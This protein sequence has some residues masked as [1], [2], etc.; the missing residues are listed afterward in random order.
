M[1][2]DDP[3]ELANSIADRI[4]DRIGR[5]WDENARQRLSTWLDKPEHQPMAI[6]WLNYMDS[7]E[8][9]DFDPVKELSLR[10]P[11][12]EAL[13]GKPAGVG[14]AGFTLRRKRWL[15]WRRRPPR[16]PNMLR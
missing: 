2:P 13:T 7:T 12:H 4:T 5:I 1:H 6:R 8:E 15:P 14:S 10:R 9:T 11:I 16:S 3:N